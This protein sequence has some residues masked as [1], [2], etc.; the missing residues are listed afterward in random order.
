[1]LNNIC[2][3]NICDFYEGMKN[4][5]PNI[6]KKQTYQFGEIYVFMKSIC[7]DKLLLNKVCKLVTPPCNNNECPPQIDKLIVDSNQI[8]TIGYKNILCNHSV[9]V[10]ISKDIGLCLTN[11]GSFILF[12][13][14]I[15]IN[16]GC[17]NVS[18]SNICLE[19]CNEAKFI[20][21]GI[22]ELKNSQFFGTGLIVNNNIFNLICYSKLYIGRI[23]LP[24]DSTCPQ[25]KFCDDESDF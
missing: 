8:L 19:S 23:K 21:N 24:C 25:N 18:N 2:G 13:E 7:I 4:I 17:I 10:T 11:G 5:D 14:N 12:K 16:N 20:N 15:L 3:C 1:M 6:L 9:S 22:I